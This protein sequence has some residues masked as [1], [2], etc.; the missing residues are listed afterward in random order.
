MS[1]SDFVIL[2]KIGEGSFSSV[3]KVSRTSDKKTY[4]LKQ[5]RRILRVGENCEFKRERER[6]CP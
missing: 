2:S 6:E 3:H 1:L 4:A 5:V